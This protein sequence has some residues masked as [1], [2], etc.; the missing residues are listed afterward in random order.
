[1]HGLVQA[2]PYDWPYDGRLVPARTALLLIDWQHDF[3][4]PGGYVDRMGYDIALTRRGIGPT[5]AS[6]EAVAEQAVEALA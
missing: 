2:H 6:N 5:A 1:M 3:C 4:G